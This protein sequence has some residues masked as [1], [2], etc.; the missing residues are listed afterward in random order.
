MP[1]SAG[2]QGLLKQGLKCLNNNYAVREGIEKD[3]ISSHP[4]PHCCP[5]GE[6]AL[7][8]VTH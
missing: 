5:A 6:K 3:Y 8:T 4:P 1:T 7:R 2:S